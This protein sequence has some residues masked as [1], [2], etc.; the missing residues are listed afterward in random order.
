M[1]IYINPQL[2]RHVTTIRIQYVHSHAIHTS[3]VNNNCTC[4]PN[5][6]RTNQTFQQKLTIYVCTYVHT[7]TNVLICIYVSV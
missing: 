6:L 3:Y 4:L 5:I 1:G 2:I 7:L